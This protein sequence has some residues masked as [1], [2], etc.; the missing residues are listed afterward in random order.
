M[1]HIKNIVSKFF[2][3]FFFVTEEELPNEEIYSRHF[4]PQPLETFTEEELNKFP[5]EYL[6]MLKC[7]E[8]SS[9]YHKLPTEY[10][11]NGAIIEKSY[12][13]QD[14]WP[15]EGDVPDC[16]PPFRINCYE[17]ILSK[18][19]ERSKKVEDLIWKH[20]FF[21]VNFSQ[22]DDDEIKLFPLFYLIFNVDGELISSTLTFYLEF[23]P[24]TYHD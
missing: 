20:L 17:C 7:E 2:S 23:Q 21:N 5:L 24:R 6:Q 14:H 22:F 19:P 12:R 11:K 15:T 13:C 10:R 8:L 1:L 9:I 3:K 16:P 4:S 18:I